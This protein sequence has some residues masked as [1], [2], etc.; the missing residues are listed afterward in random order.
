M[1][2]VREFWPFEDKNNLSPNKQYKWELISSCTAN[3]EVMINF[4]RPK[5]HEMAVIFDVLTLWF[6]GWHISP[7]LIA[8]KMQGRK[9]FWILF[10]SKLHVPFLEPSQLSPEWYSENDSLCWSIWQYSNAEMGSKLTWKIRRPSPPYPN[11][12][13]A[14]GLFSAVINFYE[15]WRSSWSLA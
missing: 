10:L 14:F 7:W 15:I 5:T 3:E 1:L 12:H 2:F 13:S 6:H 4:K 9:S 8:W 11:E